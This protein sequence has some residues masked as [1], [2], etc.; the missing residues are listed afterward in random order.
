[1][2]YESSFYITL[3]SNSAHFTD[4]STNNF[5]VRLP[6]RID[7]QGTGWEVALFDAIYPHSWQNIHKENGD[8]TLTY[9]LYDVDTKI[10]VETTALCSIPPAYYKTGHDI[11][12]AVNSCITA[13]LDQQKDL[14]VYTDEHNKLQPS[15][16]ST[17]L[18]D[19]IFDDDTSK[20]F[21]SVKVVDGFHSVKM[22]DTLA[23]ILGFERSLFSV[24][25]RDWKNALDGAYVLEAKHP[26]DVRAGLYAL[27]VYCNI[28]E[29]QIVGDMLVPLLGKMPV[30]GN[31][32]SV[33][34]TTF[35]PPLYVPI[36]R[37][38]LDVIEISIKDDLDK[39]I[40][41]QYGKVI[42]TLH[43]RK[44]NLLF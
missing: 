23:Y 6:Q 8:I 2:D 31:P 19:F 28:V 26:V 20:V 12:D 16:L 29:K 21:L 15:K 37:N 35:N 38:E 33:V 4:N 44:R 39:G 14:L 1:M 13:Q 41:F 32:D 24:A 22:S 25:D 42:L 7:L 27:Y 34:H 43:F 40:A 30:T 11:V 18:V 10:T 3:P 36:V 5:R 17:P 9:G